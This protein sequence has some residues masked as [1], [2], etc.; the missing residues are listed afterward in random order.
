[1]KSSRIALLVI[2]F[3]VAGI[4]VGWIVAQN[5]ADQGIRSLALGHQLEVAGLCVNSLQAVDE[6]R[7]PALRTMLSSRLDSAIRD[8]GSLTR[9]GARLQGA[10][11]N[12]RHTA[13]RT[14]DYLQASNSNAADAAEELARAL[15]Q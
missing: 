11:P 3:F 10:V 14:A 6:G 1:M 9:S 4:V 2:G 8:A 15:E 13:R 12:L 5:R 7:V